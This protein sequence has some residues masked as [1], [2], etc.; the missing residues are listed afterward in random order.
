[1]KAILSV[2]LLVIGSACVGQNGFT[3]DDKGKLSWTESITYDDKDQLIVDLY[4]SELDDIKEIKEDMYIATFEISESICSSLSCPIYMS[5]HL[6]SNVTIKINDD[7]YDV[8]VTNIKIY[9]TVEFFEHIDDSGWENIEQY[10][11]RKGKM[12]KGFVKHGHHYDEALF[13]V[14]SL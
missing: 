12:R 13:N 8:K 1:M 11:I 5:F 9:N 10:T 2:V 6:K 3:L 4:S 7:T 14:L